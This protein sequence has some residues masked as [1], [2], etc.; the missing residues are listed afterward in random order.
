MLSL[1]LL[2]AGSD[3]IYA[4]CPQR[5][6]ERASSLKDYGLAFLGRCTLISNLREFLDCVNRFNKLGP[7]CDLED[8]ESLGW[9]GIIS[10]YK[11]IFLMTMT[12]H[13]SS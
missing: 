9:P 13:S 7:G 6:F 8:A 5:G 1:L 2:T 11:L 4:I 12:V 3:P 10:K